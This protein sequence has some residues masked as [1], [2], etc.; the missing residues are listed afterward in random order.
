MGVC[1]NL[2]RL[3]PTRHGDLLYLFR[4]LGTNIHPSAEDLLQPPTCDRCETTRADVAMVGLAALCTA[5]REQLDCDE[6]L[7]D[8]ILARWKMD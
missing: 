6:L 7:S 2:G 4:S 3:A 5:C 1:A 8:L